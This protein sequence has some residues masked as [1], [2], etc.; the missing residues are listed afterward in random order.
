MYQIALLI[1]AYKYAN[2]YA[3]FLLSEIEAGNFRLTSIKI[4]LI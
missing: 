3:Y 4:K 1:I 2:I